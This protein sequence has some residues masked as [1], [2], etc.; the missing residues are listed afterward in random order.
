MVSDKHHAAQ[1]NAINWLVEADGSS[2]PARR[3]RDI[4]GQ[5]IADSGGADVISEARLQH[6]R[7]FAAVA[8]M[9]E[10]LEVRMVAGEEIDIAE[11]APLVSSA[12]RL[13]AKLGVNRIPRSVM[14]TL[15]E[16]LS[17][18]NGPTRPACLTTRASNEQGSL[19]ASYVAVSSPLRDWVKESAV[20]AGIVEF[21]RAQ[22]GPCG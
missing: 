9:S 20:E 21:R 6:S 16:Y 8:V 18:I 1:T 14:P 13:A 10:Q 3:F 22:S 2:A 12:V 5:L 11:H 4:C 19:R 15:G 7:R 17:A